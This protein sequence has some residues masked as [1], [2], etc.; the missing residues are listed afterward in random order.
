MPPPTPGMDDKYL[1]IAEYLAKGYKPMEVKQLTG[2]KLTEVRV[3]RGLMELGFIEFTED[4]R[5]VWARG[6]S[7]EEVRDKV[8][9]LEE[10]FMRRGRRGARLSLIHI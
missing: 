3:A 6:K 5:A 1:E 7:P 4:G 8:E 2:H 9:E 10:R